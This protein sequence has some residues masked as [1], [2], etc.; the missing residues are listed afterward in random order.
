MGCGRSFAALALCAMPMR[1]IGNGPVPIWKRIWPAPATCITR[2][3][4]AI[5]WTRSI[6][7]VPVMTDSRRV[8]DA[9]VADAPHIHRL[10]NRFAEEKLMLARSLSEAYDNIR[11]FVLYE[12]EGHVVGCGAGHV[13]WEDLA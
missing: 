3:R 5:S 13:V 11:D 10:V 6:R 1:G 7:K 8:R 4:S 12:D 2:M 9:V